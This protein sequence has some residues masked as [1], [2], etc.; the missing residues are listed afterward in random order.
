MIDK[1]KIPTDILTQFRQILHK[2]PEVSNQETKTAER[3]ANFLK[4]Y[5][6]TK[7]ITGLG[8]KSIAAIY[9]NNKTAKTILVRCELDALPIQEIND[10]EYKSKFEGVSH[11][12]GHDG[13]MAI[14][15]G[16]GAVL[17]RSKPRDLNVILLFQH[18]EEV[19]DG[20]KDILNDLEFRKL[21]PNYVIALHNVPS[22]SKHQI[23][24]KKG[25]FTPAVV[26]LIVNL[27]G[28]TSHAAEPEMG[29]NPAMA[30]SKIIAKANQLEINKDA[31][32]LQLLTP[33]QI[34]LGEEAFGISAGHAVIKY[35]LRAWSNDKLEK[36]KST[37][38]NEINKICKDEKLTSSLEWT[39]EF[40]SNYNNDQLID[41]IKLAAETLGYDVLN[42]DYPFKWGE[43][44]GLFT[45]KY[46]GVLFGLGA[47]ENTPA[48]HN[49]DYDF[50][51]ELIETGVKMFYQTIY[52]LSEK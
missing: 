38:V 39:Q 33:I 36:L 8:G 11:K 15:V 45:Q 17:S 21:E 48:L 23:V 12:C 3:I 14:L 18:A 1:I 49:P 16:L 46:P 26:S 37:F 52:Q 35:T 31:D 24:L 32:D 10:F 6:P 20:A 2:F 42:K 43:D 51:D 50:P 25:A 44:F 5:N 47:G 27:E 9:G 34:E 28:K 19:G 22:Y 7:V 40:S 4:S 29:I 41:E 13:H 30:V